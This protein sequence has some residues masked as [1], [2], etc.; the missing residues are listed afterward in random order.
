[1][2]K[3]QRHRV[4]NI[5]RKHNYLPFIIEM[6]RIVAANGQLVSLVKSAKDK[7]ENKLKGK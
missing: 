3:R 5:R 2:E 4:E 7:A 1:M 6:L